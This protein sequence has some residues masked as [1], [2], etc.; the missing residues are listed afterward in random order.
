MSFPLYYAHKES[1]WIRTKAANI[2]NTYKGFNNPN[3]NCFLHVI[4]QSFYHNKFLSS[5]AEDTKNF[6]IRTALEMMKDS[7]KQKM[8]IF[9]NDYF[10]ASNFPDIRT[11]TKTG[12]K[13]GSVPENLGYYL[14]ET[15]N[16]QNYFSIFDGK[17]IQDKYIFITTIAEK[18]YNV[19]LSHK[20]DIVFNK[21]IFIEIFNDG[22]NKIDKIKSQ[23]QFDNKVYK[24]YAIILMPPAHYTVFLSIDKQ[25][26]YFNSNLLFCLY[27]I[28][29][30]WQHYFLTS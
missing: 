30:S 26:Y 4:L 1:Q 22:K 14:M 12:T 25:I 27:N 2:D 15:S 8:S 21:F 9:E 7:T 28:L 29:S 20:Q 18:Y 19:I 11:N 17:H 6:P 24:L 13:F 16:L 10:L 3:N 23:L 5:N